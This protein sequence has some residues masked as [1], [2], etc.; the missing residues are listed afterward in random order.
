MWKPGQVPILPYA[1]VEAPLASLTPHP[2]DPPQPGQNAPLQGESGFVDGSGPLFS[3]YFKLA[4]EEDKKSTE[5]WT[6]DA[7]GILVFVSRYCTSATSTQIDLEPEDWFILRHSRSIRC[8]IR[9]G[10]QAKFSRHLGVLPRKHLSD[11]QWLPDRHAPFTFRSVHIFS[12]NLC[13]M[14]QLALVS[15]LAHQSHIRTF[16]HLTPAMGTSVLHEGHPQT[17]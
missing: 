16:G 3:M 14:D 12:T 4:E 15:Q 7:D 10:S 5:N 17:I 6:G 9:P 13:R 1:T 2:G 11:P 8:G